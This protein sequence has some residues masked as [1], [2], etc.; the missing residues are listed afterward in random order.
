MKMGDQM[1]MIF[2]MTTLK[3]G[4]DREEYENWAKE[5][6]YPFMAGLKSVKSFSIRRIE[7]DITGVDNSGWMYIE[8]IELISR[9]LYDE[10]FATE[11]GRKLREEL[12]RFIDRAANVKFASRLI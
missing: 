8:S 6:D 7:G 3:P 10:E 12:F 2:L 11:D 9:E 5:R 4:V 1:S